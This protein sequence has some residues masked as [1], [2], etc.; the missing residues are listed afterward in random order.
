MTTIKPSAVLREAVEKHLWDGEDP[1]GPGCRSL[2]HAVFRWCSRP[3]SDD[4]TLHELDRVHDQVVFRMRD[5]LEGCDSVSG[6]LFHVAKIPMEHLT[7]LQVQ[8]YR[9]RWALHLADEFEAEGL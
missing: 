8:D 1:D 5:L 4:E 7:P 3:D 9:K 6:W 2:C